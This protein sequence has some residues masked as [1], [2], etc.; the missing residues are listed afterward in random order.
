MEWL[1]EWIAKCL[2]LVT[3]KSIVLPNTEVVS[4]LKFKF[5]LAHFID[6][7]DSKSGISR[8]IPT[9]YRWDFI[10]VTAIGCQD[11]GAHILKKCEKTN[12]KPKM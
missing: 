10:V 8:S 2:L 11:L 1:K 3:T 7:H 9:Q 6:A 4:S 5:M 12:L